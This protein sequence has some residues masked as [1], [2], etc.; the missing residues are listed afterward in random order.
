MSQRTRALYRG[1]RPATNVGYSR[2]HLDARL[3]V[4]V[5]QSRQQRHAF[6]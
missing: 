3:P 6:Q 1:Q 4:L 5:A 2:E